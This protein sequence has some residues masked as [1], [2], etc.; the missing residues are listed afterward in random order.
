MHREK[1]C[2]EETPNKGGGRLLIQGG[3]YIGIFVVYIYIYT[4]MYMGNLLGEYEVVDRQHGLGPAVG[5]GLLDALVA[6]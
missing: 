5:L 6:D 4:H 1:G 2:L 3:D